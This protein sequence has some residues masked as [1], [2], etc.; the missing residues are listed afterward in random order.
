MTLQEIYQ[1]LSDIITADKVAYR[2]FPKNEAPELPY[3]I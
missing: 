3:I 2:M 1:M